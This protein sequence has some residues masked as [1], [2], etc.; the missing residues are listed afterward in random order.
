M[1]T[2]VKGF[3][4][5]GFCPSARTSALAGG[6]LTHGWLPRR[7]NRANLRYRPPGRLIG[8]HARFR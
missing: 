2:R 8:G 5:F 1:A 4:L 3:S 6:R 7:P